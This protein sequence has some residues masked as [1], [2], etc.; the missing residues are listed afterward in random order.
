VQI[1]AGNEISQ[2]VEPSALFT[3]LDYLF[4]RPGAD[5]FNRQKPETDFIPDN[6]K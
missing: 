5:V 6:C 2:R 1:D 4:H 3:S